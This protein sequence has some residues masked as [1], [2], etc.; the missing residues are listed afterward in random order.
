MKSLVLLYRDNKT[1]EVAIREFLN[2]T[3]N[4]KHYLFGT[5]NWIGNREGVLKKNVGKVLKVGDF[6][7]NCK[8]AEY[9]VEIPSLNRDIFW[10]GG[11]LIFVNKNKYDEDPT[12]YYNVI[13][14]YR[15][16]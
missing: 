11:Y 16:E 15:E 6:S 10:N 14:N 9:P 8:I 2:I 12:Y 4:N 7:T 13:K 3:E 1:K 5:K